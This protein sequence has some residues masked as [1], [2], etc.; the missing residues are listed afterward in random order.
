MKRLR[1]IFITLIALAAAAAAACGE[2]DDSGTAAQW[3]ACTLNS[4]CTLASKT[5][6]GVCG[7][8]TLADVDGVNTE[9]SDEH[10]D[11][12][13]PEPA[14]CPACPTSTNPNLLATCMEKVCQAVDVRQNPV[15]TCA[16]DTDCRLRVAA[17]CECSDST[18][19][20]DLIAINATKESAY[21]SLVCDPGQM[22]PECQ[23]IYP[24][25][26]EAYC[27]GDGHCD[28][29]PASSSVC[30]LPFE[31]GSCEARIPVFA[32]VDGACVERIYGG[33]GGNANRFQTVEECTA[34]CEGGRHI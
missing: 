10:R 30:S 11:E 13:C 25:S 28:V 19:V 1:H 16:K 34:E 18:T 21:T 15:T 29:R 5:C 24:T 9:H 22:C 20:A 17:W 8:P 2:T 12:V 3:A 23:P 27:A 6:C 33:C 26:I 4:E 14:V 31:A 7:K 32:F